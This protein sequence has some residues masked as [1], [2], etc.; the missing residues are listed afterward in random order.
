[1]E[2]KLISVI[3]PCYNAEEY[4]LKT[5]NT[6]LNQTY[7]EIELIVVDDCSSDNT[8]I[9]LNDLIQKG[10]IKYHRLLENYG[11]PSKPRNIGIR[12]AKGSWIAFL[13]ADDLWHPNKLEIQIKSLVQ[14]D[15]KFC[16]TNKFDFINL[17]EL[18]KINAVFGFWKISYVTILLKD[19]IPTSSVIIKSDI[20]KELNFNESKSL[21]SVEDYDLWIRVI[22]NGHNCLKLKSYLT[23]YRISE[24]QISKNKFKRIKLFFLM[25]KNHF[26]GY[27]PLNIILGAFFTLSHYL[28]TLTQKI[29]K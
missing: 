20:L 16:C 10:K 9:V 2:N 17:T 5:V 19:F 28:I 25:F 26:Q 1:M 14:H 24:N 11:G 15:F 3:I 8:K 13:D 23:Y 7:S 18:S 4:I 29:F 6:V 12:M 22:A 27:K 21:I